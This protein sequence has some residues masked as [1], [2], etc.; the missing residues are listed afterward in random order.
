[1]RDAACN[2]AHLDGA[3]RRYYAE[4]RLAGHRVDRLVEEG[5]KARRNRW[6]PALVTGV[7]AMLLV[8]LGGIHLHQ[9]RADFRNAVLAEVAMN[10]SKNLPPEFE[11]ANFPEVALALPRLGIAPEPGVPI[12][13]ADVAGARYCSI[14][15]RLAGLIR[16][17]VDGRRH[18]LYVTSATEEL[19]RL[20]ALEA[21]HDGV[22][23]RLWSEGDRFFAL[24]GDATEL[25]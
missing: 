9:K 12:P 6:K 1:M 17:D 8:S 23:I 20:D 10:H 2:D 18:T 5:R 7:A 16:L 14:Q 3:L 19:V 22:G 25:H 4:H 24:A 21:I 11:A 15:G 13:G